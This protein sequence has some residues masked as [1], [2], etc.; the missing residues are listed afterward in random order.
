MAQLAVES[1]VSDLETQITAG[2][3]VQLKTDWHQFDNR[4]FNMQVTDSSSD[5]EFDSGDD[6]TRQVG[7]GES[8]ISAAGENGFL[9]AGYFHVWL[10]ELRIYLDQTRDTFWNTVLV[11]VR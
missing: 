11:W 9:E 1:V 6:R 10:C 7:T 4:V 5:R 3:K 2:D 8:R